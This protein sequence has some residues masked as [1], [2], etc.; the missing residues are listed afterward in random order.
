MNTGKDISFTRKNNSK[1]FLRELLMDNRLRSASGFDES[2]NLRLPPGTALPSV[3]PHSKASVLPGQIRLLPQTDFMTYV[4]VL[5]RWSEDSF[6][7][8]PFSRFSQPATDEEFKTDYDGGAFLR[9]LQ[10]WNARSA[11]NATLCNSW[12]V[13]E[14]SEQD[15]H[16]AL[17]V[18]KWS[19]GDLA[20]LPE[21]ISERTGVP[22]YRTDDPRLDYRREALEN[23]AAFDVEDDANAEKANNSSS[24]TASNSNPVLDFVGEPARKQGVAFRLVEP[25]QR[26]AAASLSGNP[27]RTFL[28]DGYPAK[29]RGEYS[30][31]EK[32]LLFTVWDKD[33]RIKSNVLDGFK[34]RVEGV[35][36][37]VPILDKAARVAVADPS[38][39][40]TLLAPDGHEVMLT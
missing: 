35:G 16:D 26:A 34:L 40:F 22:I 37:E 2:E 5:G 33:R 8:A 18:W 25:A 3:F 27:R 14:L 23:F 39:G 13:G 30:I 6:L 36:E 9:V 17:L 24:A 31:F 7:I 12:L 10:L 11:M 15:C 29:L 4:A 28:V 1:A 19:I 20:E 32:A 21:H 38:A